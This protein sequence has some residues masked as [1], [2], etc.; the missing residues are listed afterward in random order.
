MRA[1]SDTPDRIEKAALELFRRDG[2][3]QVSMRKI[4][5]EVGVTATALYRHYAN[6]AEIVAGLVSKGFRTFSHYLQRESH[7]DPFT[8]LMAAGAGY[9]DFAHEHPHAYWLMFLTDWG[10]L[11]GENC[12]EAT[13]EADGSFFVLVRMVAA[14]QAA[15]Q[16]RGDVPP[17]MLAHSIWSVTHGQASLWLKLGD[18][19][20]QGSHAAYVQAFDFALNA[21]MNGLR[22]SG[23]HP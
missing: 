8:Q 2:L 17:E 22:P 14:C 4:A 21:L 19:F 3:T 11:L 9:R 10:D 7:P 16:L 6:K 23:P 12:A 20:L 13:N 18:H 5:A 15:G 1:P